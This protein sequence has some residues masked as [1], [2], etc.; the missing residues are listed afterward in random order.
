VETWPNG[1]SLRAAISD[2]RR[3]SWLPVEGRCVSRSGLSR[4]FRSVRSVPGAP[5]VAKRRRLGLCVDCG[6]R[7]GSDLRLCQDCRRRH[8]E[9]STQRRK[10]RRSLDLCSACGRKRESRRWKTCEACRARQVE[11]NRAH[12]RRR[13]RPLRRAA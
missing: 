13:D 1:A 9:Y 7:R 6:R 5:P 4:K 11:Y 10:V 2:G 8:R 12:K 3:R